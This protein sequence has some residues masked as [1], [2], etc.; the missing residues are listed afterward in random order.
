MNDVA[1]VIAIVALAFFA[2]GAFIYVLLHPETR[3]GQRKN[4][5]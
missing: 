3:G 4:R 1:L 5:W 2:G